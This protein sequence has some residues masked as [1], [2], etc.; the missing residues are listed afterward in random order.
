MAP[1][2]STRH[3]PNLQVNTR[4]FSS[5]V[6]LSRYSSGTLTPSATLSHSP[7]RSAGFK[8]STSYP[9]SIRS[10]RHSER[11]LFFLCLHWFRRLLS[12]RV[13]WLLTTLFALLCWW[14][15]TGW[16]DFDAASARSRS[17]ARGVLDPAGIR[18]LQFFP[19]S[20]PK[21]RVR[22]GLSRFVCQV[23]LTTV[24]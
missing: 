4:S 12:S 20:N 19:A 3:R 14:R 5:P 15:P 16:Q 11:N 1:S 21:I 6:S 24:I 23:L 2:P 8:P 18:N 10:P 9:G 13:L 7:Y 17:L 22:Q